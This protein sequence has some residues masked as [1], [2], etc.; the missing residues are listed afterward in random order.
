MTRP[1][2]QPDIDVRR[3]RDVA[4]APARDLREL[5][6]RCLVAIGAGAII[7]MVMG[8][9][10]GRLVM[11]VIRR[12][13]DGSVQGL[14]TDDGFRIG[15]FT[16]ATLFLVSVA[17]G[18]GGVTGALYLALRSSLPRRGRATM[19]GAGVGLFTSADVLMPDKFDF[20]AL[21]PKPFIVT[22][23]VV[24]PVVAALTI[25]VATERLL[26]VEPW[27]QRRLTAI[28]ALSV[29]PL[30]PALPVMALAAAVVLAARR[31]PEL[32]RRLRRPSRLLVP[33][34]LCVVAATSAVEVWRDAVAILS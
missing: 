10:G 17:A 3:R 29:L 31:L 13:S 1:P 2:D 4:D 15:Q 28:L 12:G 33:V 30:V 21:E 20:A 14:L 23:F 26:T 19:W 8:G 18:L 16:T 7:G 5:A 11:F 24:L 34:A 32:R 27:S 25:A 6:W 9:L 22:S